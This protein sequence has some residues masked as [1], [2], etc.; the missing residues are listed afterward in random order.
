MEFPLPYCPCVLIIIGALYVC[1]QLSVTEARCRAA[2]GSKE[3]LGEQLADIEKDK[4][5]LEKKV[6]QLQTKLNKATSQ[7]TEEKEV[8]ACV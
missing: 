6:G 3:S 1:V 2:V 5:G 8:G 4:K 7:L